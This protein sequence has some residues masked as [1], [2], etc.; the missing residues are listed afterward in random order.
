MR[1]GIL[2]LLLALYSAPALA[3]PEPFDIRLGKAPPPSRPPDRAKV[4]AVDRFL[5]A[6][7]TGNQSQKRRGEA[8]AL[9][10]A[11]ADDGVLFGPGGEA[12]LAY[13]FH[14]QSIQPAGKGAFRVEVYLLFA[15]KDGVVRESRNET[16]L[17]AARGSGYVCSSIRPT[18]SIQWD[19]AAVAK[20][21]GAIGA[22]EALA[23]AENVLH[24]WRQRQQW[25]AAYS[26][27]D[28]KLAG[29][30]SVLVQCLR[31]T[32]NRGRRGFDSKDSTLVLRKE[33]S[34]GYRVDSN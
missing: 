21:A 19:Q 15:D 24:A 34:G 14:D 32:A 3:G 16:L 26:V 12:L 9:L 30:G 27:A 4:A 13:D 28:V 29:D 1:R 5:A 18:G 17:F 10:A 2:L 6:R 11:K 20:T 23:R 8:R 31:F 22:D 7:Q 25:N 33:S